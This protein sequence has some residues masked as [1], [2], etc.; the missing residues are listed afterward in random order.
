MRSRDMSAPF[1]RVFDAVEP[2]ED[3]ICLADFVE[4]PEDDDEV[5]EAPQWVLVDL[6]DA[7]GR[8]HAV[9][10]QIENHPPGFNVRT[11]GPP[12]N[13]RG[14]RLVGGGG[15]RLGRAGLVATAAIVESAASE[16]AAV[17]DPSVVPHRKSRGRAR[18]E[19]NPDP[20]LPES[21]VNQR[22]G[23]VDAKLFMAMV[24]AGEIPS[25]Q[26]GHL[27]FARWADYQAAFDRLLLAQA[28]KPQ[29][30]DGLDDIRAQLG[31]R[32]K[33]GGR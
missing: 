16:E 3:T 12:E 26:C 17:V 21:A 28:R 5:P 4:V 30:G 10:T 23:V 7:D 32:P 33:S 15:Q 19:R 29:L 8:R 18:T 1:H 31:L 24:R 27:H 14:L 9:H 22:M 20:L 2:P 6:V 11:A 13:W 25:W